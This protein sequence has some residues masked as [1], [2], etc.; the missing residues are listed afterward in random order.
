M[1]FDAEIDPDFTALLRK[2]DV[3]A[4]NANS[5][6]VYGLWQDYRLA[7]LNPGWFRFARDNG[8]EPEVSRDW[9]LGRCVL[10]AM[11]DPLQTFFERAFAECGRTREVWEHEYQCCSDTTFRQM[12]QF[13]YPLEGAG[14]LVTNTVVVERPYEVDVA[15]AGS[16]SEEDYRNQHGI[17]TQCAHCRMVRNLTEPERWDWVPE[18]VARCPEYTSHGLCS[19]CLGHYY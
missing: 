18:W 2:Y 14:F 17:V 15:L 12:R 5:G 10:D 16:A 8:G 9:G 1:P 11:I 3:A 6:S 13:V 19:V 7:Y 4:L